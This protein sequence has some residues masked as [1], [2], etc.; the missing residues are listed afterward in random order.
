MQH[1]VVLWYM[2]ALYNVPI[3][4]NPNASSSICY[5]LWKKPTNLLF[6]FFSLI[7][8]SHWSL[9][10]PCFHTDRQELSG[11]NRSYGVPPTMEKA[12]QHP[13]RMRAI[14]AHMKHMT[15]VLFTLTNSSC[16]TTVTFAVW[17]GTANLAW[18]SLFFFI[19][20][21]GE[22]SFSLLTLQP[23]HFFPIS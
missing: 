23:Q 5:S 8:Y 18:L 1:H 10:C 2:Q 13:L 14:V 7:W 20:S 4:E 21:P 3:R 22:N 15:Y 19:I 17:S 16:A 6:N 11:C 9:C 12:F